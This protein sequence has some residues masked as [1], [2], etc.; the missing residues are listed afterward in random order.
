MQ[1]GFCTMG[2][3]DYTT[4]EEAVRRIGKAGYQLVDFWAYSPHLGPD[5]YNFV[6]CEGVVDAVW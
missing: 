5:L 6:G 1:L 2:Y 3:L 4:V